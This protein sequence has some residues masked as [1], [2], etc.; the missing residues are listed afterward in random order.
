MVA[1]FAVF[2]SLRTLD[3]KQMGVGL[4]VAVLLDAT[5][6]R[7]VLL[8]AAMKLLGEWNWYLPRWLEWLPRFNVEPELHAPP[9]V[10]VPEPAYATVGAS[11]ARENVHT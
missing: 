5:L 3:I 7:G 10:A 2:A 1:V 6:I 9:P 8:P 4:A 11:E